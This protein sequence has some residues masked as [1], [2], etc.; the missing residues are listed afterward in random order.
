MNMM[1]LMTAVAPGTMMGEA[2]NGGHGGVDRAH[3][4]DG[5]GR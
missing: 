3:S 4:G 5:G 2:F 1:L